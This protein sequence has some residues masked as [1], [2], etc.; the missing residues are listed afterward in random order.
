ML[1]GATFVMLLNLLM[2]RRISNIFFLFDSVDRGQACQTQVADNTDEPQ[3][4][5][6]TESATSSSTKT[7]VV[8]V[9]ESDRSHTRP[10]YKRISWDDY[11]IDSTDPQVI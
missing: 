8:G 11:S 10:A 9:N 2:F 6:C 3:Q 5:S 7:P 4:P 1:G